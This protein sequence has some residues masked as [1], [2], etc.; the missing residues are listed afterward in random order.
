MVTFQVFPKNYKNGI[1]EIHIYPM[2]TL[3]QHSTQLYTVGCIPATGEQTYLH[4]HKW[5]K[6]RNLSSMN[7]L[8]FWTKQIGSKFYLHPK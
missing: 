2:A 6:V 4:Q 7:W 3:V 8:K 5:W 1:F